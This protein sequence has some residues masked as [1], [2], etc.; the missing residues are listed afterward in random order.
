LK[1][2]FSTTF[3]LAEAVNNLGIKWLTGYSQ[4]RRRK[5]LPE[6][7]AFSAKLRSRGVR[8]LA[9]DS[10]TT[11]H[12]GPFLMAGGRLRAIDARKYEFKV[13]ALLTT[14][15]LNYLFRKCFLILFA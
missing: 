9:P 2:L 6:S 14:L 4:S 12:F 1:L 3:S 5:I 7:L 8:S 15:A 11:Y 13:S 10:F